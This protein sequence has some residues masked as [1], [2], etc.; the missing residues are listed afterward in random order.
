MV[1]SRRVRKIRVL[2]VIGTRPEVIK[3]A[4]VIKELGRR[5]NRFSVTTVL[6]GQHREMSRPYLSLFDIRPDYDLAIMQRA[7]TLDG[8]VERILHRLHPVLKEVGPDLVLVQGDTTSAFAASLAAFHQQ[9]A[10]GHVEAGLRTNNKYNPFPEE[11]S[12]RL[13]GALAD[14]HFAPT[15]LARRS[16]LREAVAPKDIFVTGNTVIDALQ[17]ISRRRYAF[18]DPSLARIP[19]AR[20]RVICVTTHRRESI[21]VPMRNI[22]HAL[23]RLAELYADVEIVIPVHY[24]PSVRQEV[25]RLLSAVDRVHLVE[26]LGYEAFVHLMKR[27]Y[28]VLTDSGGVQEEAP[29]LGKPVLVLRE[30]TER[31]EGIQAGTAKLVGTN[32]DSI[33]S[34]AAKLLNDPHAYRA[35]AQAVN[36]YGDGRASARIARILESRFG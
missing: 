3:M 13:V 20:R 14:L 31:P 19:Y 35:M 34:A 29:A 17:S 16:L 26:P 28:L 11:M 4:P 23:R 21:G 7:Q 2:A 25:F 5:N 10:V 12:R 8:I 9:I 27:S 33:V 36:P 15:Q 30:T 22:L 32:A 18:T 1:R 6:T 24:N